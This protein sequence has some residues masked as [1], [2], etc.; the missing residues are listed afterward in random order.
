MLHVGGVDRNAEIIVILDSFC[1]MYELP[2]QTWFILMICLELKLQVFSLFP[3]PMT[4]KELFHF[5]KGLRGEGNQCAWMEAQPWEDAGEEGERGGS[6]TKVLGDK[7]G[8]PGGG[9]RT[10]K[11][12]DY[13]PLR[14]KSP[15]S[16]PGSS[17]NQRSPAF[18]WK[19]CGC[20]DKAA[21]SCIGIFVS[22]VLLTEVFVKQLRAQ[23][24]RVNVFISFC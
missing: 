24:C 20:F 23:L 19:S 9:K 11:N 13:K 12:G 5:S 17:G 3:V 8:W 4:R 16:F 21:E 2:K 1:F 22:L 18:Q 14:S 7:E 10:T 6:G 15:G